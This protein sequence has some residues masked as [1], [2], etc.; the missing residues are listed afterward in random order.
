MQP[1]YPGSDPSSS[2]CRLCH[3]GKL[4]GLSGPQFPHL[5]SGGTQCNLTG[6]LW[7]LNDLIQK[8]GLHTQGLLLVGAQWTTAYNHNNKNRMQI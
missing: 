8:S 1:G 7:G 4:L 5:Y 3:L 6:L 2:S